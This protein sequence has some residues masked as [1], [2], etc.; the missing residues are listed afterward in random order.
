[1][2]SFRCNKNIA[3]LTCYFFLQHSVFVSHD[4]LSVQLDQPIPWFKN[5]L[6][7]RPIDQCI[8]SKLLFWPSF[9]FTIF[10]NTFD[11]IPMQFELLGQC[12]I[13]NI[14]T[15]KLKSNNR[16]NHCQ[17]KDFC[18]QL[19]SPSLLRALCSHAAFAVPKQGRGNTACLVHLACWL[20]NWAG[21]NT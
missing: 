5:I 11:S 16:H 13:C 7:W 20:S 6:D 1:M 2:Y 14:Q 21:P 3:R 8:T 12:R 9:F 10:I 15:C 18:V 19:L 4:W 17:P